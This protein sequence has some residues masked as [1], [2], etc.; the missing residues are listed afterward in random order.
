MRH[1][2][3][4]A[5]INSRAS[6]SALLVSASLLLPS[7]DRSPRQEL[8]LLGPQDAA[9]QSTGRPGSTSFSGEATALRATVLGSTTTISHA[10]PLPGSGGAQEASLLDATVPGVA[11]AHVLHAS[12]VAQGEHSRSEASTADLNLTVGGQTVG[13]SLLMARA[14]ARCVSGTAQTSGSSQVADLVINGQSIAVS[15]APNQTVFLPL[16]AGRVIVNEQTAGPGSITVN[17]LHVIVTGVAD[18]VVSSAHADIECAGQPNCDS[19]RDFVTGGG[20]ITG[21]PSGAKGTFGVAGGVKNGALW[22]HL[23]YIDHGPGGPKVKGTGVTAY[24]IVNP[25]TRHIE[26]TCEV[27]GQTGFTYKVDVADNGEPGRNDT[28]ALRLS[29]GYSASGTLGGGNIQLHFP[30]P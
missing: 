28:F 7:C 15:G 26:G 12:T 23:T 9:S 13:A 14:E 16:G 25:T 20:W 22:G 21:A 27:N 10:G 29:N 24:V 4:M 17:A 8:R 3:L 18:V 11:T 30:C 1:P 5:W 19:S 2:S 6:I